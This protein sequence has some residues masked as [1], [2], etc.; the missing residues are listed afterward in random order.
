LVVGRGRIQYIDVARFYAM[1]M[2]FYGHF[3]ERVMLLNDP[4]AATLYKFIYS[5]HM[6]VFFVLSGFISKDSDLELGF[7][8]FLKNRFLSRLLPF[9][10]FTIVFIILSAIFPGDFYSLKLPSAEGYIQGLIMTVLGIPL[11]CVPSWFLMMIFSVEVVHH[12]AFRFFKSNSRFFKLDSKIIIGMVAFYIGGYYLNL[13]GDFLNLGKQRMYNVL[14]IHEAITMYAFYLLGVYL[15]RRKF[16]VNNTS[17]KILVPGVVITF[18]VVLLTFRLNNGPFNFNYYNSV[19]IIMSAHGHILWF[20]LTAVA[21][22][23]F[24]FFLGRITPP[25]KTIFWMGQNTLIL[26]CLNGIFYHYINPWMGKW[27]FM[28]FSGQPFVIFVLGLFMTVVSLALCMPLIFIL[29]R[30]VPQLVGKPKI[31]GPWLKNFI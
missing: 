25:Q 8:K 12:V 15:R 24:I 31:N 3:I 14:F 9:I 13:Y 2:V 1:A 19:V 21:G 17:Y 5:F 6:I 26:M 10:F 11:F 16:L 23:L 4:T 18:L 20:P 22:S 28:N 27:V 30:Y 29:N 7:W